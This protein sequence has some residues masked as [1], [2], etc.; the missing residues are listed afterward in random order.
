VSAG[1]CFAM[2]A[3]CRYFSAALP[4]GTP[5][6]PQVGE[7]GTIEHSYNF[8]DTVTGSARCGICR[9]RTKLNSQAF[10]NAST[11]IAAAQMR[12]A[13]TALSDTV[14][15]AKQKK[16]RGLYLGSSC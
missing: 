10:E 15:D 1:Q 5:H 12:N 16:V 8:D 9:R 2:D 3:S 7:R 4:V 11:N 13:L 6:W 14:K